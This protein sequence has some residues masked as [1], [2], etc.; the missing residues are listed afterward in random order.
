MVGDCKGTE[1]NARRKRCCNKIKTNYI[2]M[3]CKNLA[4]NEGMLQM[5]KYINIYEKTV[6]L[7][8]MTDVKALT[9]LINEIQVVYQDDFVK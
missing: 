3:I 5:C 6:A 8:I 1:T 2:K 9:E 4:V 7:R